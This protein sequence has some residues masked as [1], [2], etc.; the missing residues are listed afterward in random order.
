MTNLPEKSFPEEQPDEDSPGWDG[1]AK[2]VVRQAVKDYREARALLRRRK[3]GNARHAARALMEDAERFF[4]SRWFE[5][6]TD[7]DGPKLAEALK[8]EEER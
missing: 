6:L 5:C 7:M 4:R 8:K 2:A 3:R 1:L